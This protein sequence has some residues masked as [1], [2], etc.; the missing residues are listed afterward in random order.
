MFWL[1]ICNY[2]AIAH[3]HKCETKIS[4][5]PNHYMIQNT[6]WCIYKLMFEKRL[7]NGNIDDFKKYIIYIISVSKTNM[8]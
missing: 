3:F 6:L 5:Q 1:Y 2:V 4:H 7:E 8:R